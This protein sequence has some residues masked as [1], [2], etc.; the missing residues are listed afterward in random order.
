M[1]TP[2]DSAPTAPEQMPASSFNI[3]APYA[4]SALAPIPGAARDDVAGSVASSVS[5]A[6]ARYSAHEADTH[7][8]GSTLGTLMDMPV[9][10]DYSVATAHEGAYDGGNS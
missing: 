10:P 3:Q 1:I 7:G 6:E 2:A 9:H 4:T 5:A 8:L